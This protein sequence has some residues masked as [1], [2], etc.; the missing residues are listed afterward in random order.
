MNFE[1]TLV[2]GPNAA[3]LE[4]PEEL[5][6]TVDGGMPG[7]E[8]QRQLHK[9]RGVGPL[10]VAGEDLSTL[11]VG[12]PPLVAGAVLVDGH[13]PAEKSDSPA[14]PLLL[15]AHT[16]PGAGT[17]FALQRGHHH[18]GRGDVD[19][20]IPDPGMSREHAV[21]R[22]SSTAL[23]I[24]DTGS[25]NWVL[26]DGERVRE[27]TVTSSS[28]IRCG[29][30]S[31]TIVTPK[32]STPGIH[33]D[34]GRSVEVPLE[35][36]RQAGSLNRWSVAV[37][38]GLPLV[39]GV[40]LALATGMWMFL[41][42]TA[43]SALS[44]LVPMITGRKGRRE[45]RLAVATAALQDAERRRRCSPSAAEIIVATLAPAAGLVLNP[46]APLALPRPGAGSPVAS[47]QGTAAGP[48]T[49]V[50][51]G[52]APTLA[53]VRPVPADPHFRPPAI[54]SMPV[55]LGLHPGIVELHGQTEH[56]DAL[57]RFIVMQLAS[58]PGSSAKPIILLGPIGRLPLSARFLPYLTLATNQAA[59]TAALRR[60]KGTN[61][62]RLVVLDDPSGGDDGNTKLLDAALEAS[63]QVLR[64][65][66]P[67]AGPTGVVIEIGQSGTSAVLQFPGGLQE[68]IP[69]MVPLKAFDQFCRTVASTPHREGPADD[70]IPGFCSLNDLLPGGPR[71]ILRRWVG[72]NGS[73]ELQAILGQGQDGP[74]T[75][76]FHVDG[77]HLLVAG[78][79]GAGKSELLRTIVASMA[80]NHSPDQVTFLFVDFKGGSGLRPLLGLPHCVGLLTDLGSHHLDRV[81]TSLRGEIRR[82]EELFA[83]LGTSDLAAYQRSPAA[84]EA[85]V[86]HLVLVVDEFRM[87]VDEAPGALRELMRVAAI[88]RSLGIHLVM[89][90]QRPQGALTADIRANVTSSVA[91]RV[92]SDAESMDIIN[93]KA[94]ASIGVD[95]P[96]RAYLVRATGDPEEFQT[97]SLAVP[98]TI[99]RRAPGAAIVQ[100][101]IGAL[102][103][104]PD[105]QPVAGKS[106][107]QAEARAEGVVSATRT[108]WR[109]LGR[110]DPRQP[111]APLLPVSIGWS[112]DLST[113]RVAGND[114]ED[115][116]D[117]S[118]T[119]VGPLGIVDRPEQ[120]SVDVLQWSPSEHG[121][122]AMIGSSS[123]GMH[124]CF[125]AASAMLAAHGTPPHLYILDAAGM[126]GKLRQGGSY[127]ATL[128][129]HQLALAVRV[130]ER[131]AEEMARRRAAGED[132][133]TSPRLVLVVTGFCSWAAAL[134]SGRFAWAEDLLRDIIRDGTPLG[135]TVLISGERELVSSRFF[136][137]I[138]NRAF[139]PTGATEE[140]RYH[141]P[142]LPEVESVPGRAVAMGGFVQGAAT[143]VHF[144]TAPSGTDWPFVDLQPS[145]EP[146]FRIRPLPESLS[147]SDFDVAVAA[148]PRASRRS[149]ESAQ[150]GSYRVA[151]EDL[152]CGISPDF[153]PLWIGIG[154]D[155]SVPVSFPLAPRGVSIIIGGRGSGKT[156][157]LTSLM[158][159]NPQV[160][161][162]FPG[163]GTTTGAF[164]ATVADS[165]T[166]GSLDP[167]SILCVD[168]ADL[169]DPGGRAALAALAGRTRGV[170]M[171]AT[172]GPGLLQRLPL[173]AEAQANG[174]GLILAPRTPLDGDILGVRLEIENSPRAGR[175]V[176]VRGN[177][178]VQVQVAFTTDSAT[179]ISTIG[180]QGSID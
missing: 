100:S 99:S 139:F 23:S 156:S 138:P 109:S 17:V 87:L 103:P 62:G 127:G 119:P 177:R 19:I 68:F 80:L 155:E 38:A 140:S 67:Y 65:S 10:S 24:T 121:H 115:A 20:R 130:L 46:Q 85:A 18:I 37:A 30:T 175:G 153:V 22:V 12:H 45:F 59:A 125:K 48:E 77:P 56:V 82:R 93:S 176:I 107:A 142:R 113:F 178:A 169:L 106:T 132:V 108:A 152:E 72:E 58:F 159:L 61:N 2:R 43:V 163:A 71:G 167:A 123:S 52:T 9:A 171:T 60:S 3:S 168:D 81:L 150:S 160:P 88:G 15:L 154:G 133:S 36:Q 180:S 120:Q 69:D 144:R 11:T 101:A 16:G 40:G 161:W 145:S 126:L 143:M 7:S 94:A 146:P 131:L 96:G 42:F 128:G 1:C 66:G 149:P 92:Q 73:N 53:N 122:L 157:V 76:D 162:I 8:L 35:V 174:K 64:H 27:K 49:W 97:A 70:G 74:L 148:T 90:T 134:R 50:R 84:T 13:R 124:E 105:K 110:A 147:T 34:A 104:P 55:T 25:R 79:T 102:N 172:S 28:R 135:V 33:A 21:L 114:G 51:L 86:P 91:L 116:M 173:A 14:M 118:I 151:A 75:F 111:V 179:H 4:P 137:A 166:A 5:T 95:V 31:F 164:W 54:G 44:L 112:E 63:W 78:T 165:A 117:A 57:I 136:G 141:W 89:A 41:G 29:N 98:T 158:S 47:R 170:I 83:D 6:I 39:A 32:S 129:L 26:V